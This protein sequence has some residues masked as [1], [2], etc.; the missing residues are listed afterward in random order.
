MQLISPRRRYFDL[1]TAIARC[2]RLLDLDADPGSDGGAGEPDSAARRRCA[3]RRIPGVDGP[4]ATLRIV[5]GQQVS[6]ARR[7]PIAARLVASHGTPVVDPAGSLTHLFPSA[8]DLRA[9][10][11]DTFAVPAR[12]RATSPGSWRRWPTARWTS[13]RRRRLGAGPT[14]P[15]RPLPGIGPGRPR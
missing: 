2:R 15:R 7:A 5:L 3:N 10:D 4:E 13:T 8:Q 1:P 14:Q 9:V 11:P 6:T 12:R